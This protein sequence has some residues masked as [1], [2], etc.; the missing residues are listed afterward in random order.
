MH[1]RKVAAMLLGNTWK[2]RGVLHC[3]ENNMGKTGFCFSMLAV[4][5]VGST[6]CKVQV[7][8]S[9][10]GDSD[11]V[12]IATPFGGVSVNKNQISPAELGLPA[13][14]GAVLQG[15]ND[16]DKSAKVD[17]GFG[18]WKL[19]VRVANYTTS[20]NLDQVLTFYRK[21][22]GEYGTVIQCEDN[23]PVGEPVATS[24]G[25]HCDSDDH[26]HSDHGEL[27]LK[28]GSPRHQHI[29]SIDHRNHSGTHFSLI[30]LDL[31]HGFKDEQEGTN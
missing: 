23:K 30:A 20:D 31:P 19:K 12:K 11:Q 2:R 15:D 24:E 29:V 27:Q 17:L 26:S 9:H 5:L 21:A 25:L 18:S 22:L 13:Y 28:A 7:D 10:D 6:G 14:P 8:K 1:R 16:G 3:W 4:L